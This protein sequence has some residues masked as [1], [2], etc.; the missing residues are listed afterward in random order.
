MTAATRQARA[1][2]RHTDPR[3]VLS[4]VL[5]YVVLIALAA[6]YVL[7]MYWMIRSSLM[8]STQIASVRPYVYWPREM[9]WQNYADA[10]TYVPFL[11]YF[12]N[13]MYVIVLVMTGTLLTSTLAAFAFSRVEWRGRDLW[14]AILMTGLMLPGAVTIIPTYI[15]WSK[16]SAINTFWPLTLPAFFGGGIFNIFLLRQFFHSIPKELDEAAFVDGASYFQIYRRVIL[17]LARPAIIVVALFRFLD[18]W[19]DYFGPILYLNDPKKFTLAIGLLSF[20]GQY[21]TKWNLVMAASTV[22]VLPC[23]IIFLF[24]QKQLIEGIA[25]TGLKG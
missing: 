15:G 6:F 21:A 11:S 9:L 10:M 19:N 2:H 16:L 8:T 7:P 22:V 20:R 5:L 4:R 13:T 18:V 1:R 24:G 3:R 12:L 23:V 14:F 17:P 25:L